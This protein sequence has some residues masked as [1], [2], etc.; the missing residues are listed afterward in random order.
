MKASLLK[1]G[2][3]PRVA[4]AM[5][6][7]AFFMVAAILSSLSM[8]SLM[9]TDM[10]LPTLP[11][12]ADDLAASTQAAQLTLV[13]FF[14]GLG[15]SQLI[16]GP[17]SDHYGRRPV[18]LASVAAFGL[19]SVICG[20]APNIETLLIARFIQALA[21]GSMVVLPRAIT[22]DLYTGAEATKL[23]GIMSIVT[24]VSPMLAPLAGSGVLLIGGWR[25][26]FWVLASFTAV[27][28]FVC[29]RRLP[30][31]TT[32]QRLQ[33]S[34]EET[35]IVRTRTILTDGRFM[36]PA[37]ISSMA[38]VCFSVLIT[39]APFVYI[40]QFGLSPTGF[41]IA[42]GTNALGFIFG[43]A[44][45]G[46]LQAKLGG[47]RVL[48]LGKAVFLIASV[49]MSVLAAILDVSMP[50]AVGGMSVVLFGLGL[51]LPTATVLA[52][53]HF[54]T[55]SGLASSLIGA[56]QMLI[57]GS[58]AGLLSLMFDGSYLMMIGAIAIAALVASAITV[59]NDQKDPETERNTQ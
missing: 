40:E 20:L 29:L 4:G 11:R 16:G 14:F 27:A 5:P 22:I 47:L 26:I 51:I 32:P 56:L 30:E 35:L 44:L 9:A 6:V 3:T 34:H 55:A 43:A 31:T 46:P 41:G 1:A 18:L 12:L 7:P 19:A 23:I 2:N 59:P 10:Y 42:F 49:G 50:V 24:A 8:L 52:L 21:A 28:F 57:G 39:A 33:P 54:N 17:L 13:V 45:G 25:S 58:A 48:L 36:R 53:E 38:F 37:L 15:L